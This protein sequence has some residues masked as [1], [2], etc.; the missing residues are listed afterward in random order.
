MDFLRTC[1]PGYIMESNIH[2]SENSQN[3]CALILFAKHPVMGKVKTRLAKDTD[4]DFALNIYKCFI[5]DSLNRFGVVDADLIMFVRGKSV[6]GTFKK[7]FSIKIP[8]YPQIT[9][10][11]GLRMQHAM[12]KMFLQD[13]NRVAIVGSDSPDLPV[14]YINDA[15]YYLSKNDVVI[16]P[17]YD[18]GYYLIGCS[19]SL[20]LTRLFLNIEWSTNKVL[21]QTLD[22]IKTNGYSCHLLEKWRDIDTLKDLDFCHKNAYKT[23]FINSHTIKYLNYLNKR[24]KLF[25]DE[26]KHLY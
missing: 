23:E 13:Y 24:E 7:T 22:R 1:S 10:D 9:G 11:L 15:F 17:S 3:R 8:C 16:G 2:Q 4:D 20:P 25:I 26:S 14:S 21:S 19:I 12:Q 18:G 6:I 5:K